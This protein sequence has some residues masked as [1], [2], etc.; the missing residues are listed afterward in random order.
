APVCVK[1]GCAVEWRGKEGARCVAQM[2]LA[3]QQLR[4]VEAAID[5]AQL[6][7]QQRALKQLL[8]QPDRHG[9]EKLTEAARRRGQVS[10]KQPL[11]LEKRLF[12]KHHRMEGWNRH[13]GFDPT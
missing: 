4:P 9:H 2:M 11:E 6:A 7:G 3:E 8:A 12:V 13:P 10:F 1:N 5:V